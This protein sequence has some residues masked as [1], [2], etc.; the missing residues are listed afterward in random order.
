M[1]YKAVKEEVHYLVCGLEIKTSG[2]KNA[3]HR[4]QHCTSSYI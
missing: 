1:L 4:D 3:V 2:T